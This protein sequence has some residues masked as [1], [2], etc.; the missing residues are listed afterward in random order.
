[1]EDTDLT[2]RISELEERI[3]YIEKKFNIN[4][5]APEILFPKAAKVVEDEL[6]TTNGDE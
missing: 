5:N 3:D 1:M 2:Q 6:N 4:R